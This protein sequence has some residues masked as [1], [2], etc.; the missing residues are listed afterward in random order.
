MAI[1]KLSYGRRLL[2]VDIESML[3]AHF[4]E[5]DVSFIKFLK[6]SLYFFIPHSRFLQAIS[7]NLLG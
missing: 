6:K 3:V 7:I 1:L 2:S 4:T 5:K